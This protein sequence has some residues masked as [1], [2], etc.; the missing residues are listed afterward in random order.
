[1]GRYCLRNSKFIRFC[2]SAHWTDVRISHHYFLVLQDPLRFTG[3]PARLSAY[4]AH[5]TMHRPIISSSRQ[6]WL[7][8]PFHFR[9]CLWRKTEGRLIFYANVTSL[10]S[11]YLAIEIKH[12]GVPHST[13]HFIP[14]HKTHW[15]KSHSTWGSRSTSWDNWE[16]SNVPAEPLVK[17]QGER[18]VCG[19]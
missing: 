16:D 9:L 14:L 12:P 3:L 17:V 2:S 19:E 18:H 5:H 7:M 13:V 1:M 15:K 4:H 11:D 6:L 8:H 10:V